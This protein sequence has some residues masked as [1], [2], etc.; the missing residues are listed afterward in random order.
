MIIS[1]ISYLPTIWTQCE[2]AEPSVPRRRSR[3]RVTRKA[4]CWRAYKEPRKIIYNDYY[5][6]PGD[7]Y[8]NGTSD[9]QLHKP[10]NDI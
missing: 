7:Y 1:I 6:M 4:K 8:V 2:P 5:V 10:Y 9:N 3:R